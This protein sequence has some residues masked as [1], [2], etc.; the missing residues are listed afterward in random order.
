M[1]SSVPRP[2]NRFGPLLFLAAIAPGLLGSSP[3]AN[4]IF[5]TAGAPAG[6]PRARASLETACGDTVRRDTLYLSFEP[7]ADEST[8]YGFSGELFIYAAPGDTL[9]NFWAM[10]RGGANN[11]GLVIQFGPDE[12]FPGTQPWSAAVIASVTYDRTPQSGRFRFLCAVPKPAAGPVRA[13][14]RYVLGRLILGAKRSGLAGCERPVCLEWHSASFA[15]SA[16]R[17]VSVRAGGSRWLP[18]GAGLRECTE[19]IPAWR[20]KTVA[21]PAPSGGPRDGK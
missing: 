11:G 6:M 2:K 19:R 18:R 10:E 5:L 12:S 21:Q 1:T 15:Y 17:S 4:R 9:E 8:F 14:Q 7:A 20:P 16:S 3:A 13:G